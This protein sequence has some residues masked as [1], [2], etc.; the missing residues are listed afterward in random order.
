MRTI[1]AALLTFA[2]GFALTSKNLLADTAPGIAG[3]KDT[4]GLTEEQAIERTRKAI[5]EYLSVDEDGEVCRVDEVW[6][7]ERERALKSDHPE[8]GPVFAITAYAKG[9]RQGC[10]ATGNYDCRVAFRQP[11]ETGVWVTES[12]DCEPVSPQFQD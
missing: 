12:T 8:R 3:W 7:L 4:P 11:P 9:P 5:D 2:M 1:A 10:S 6:G